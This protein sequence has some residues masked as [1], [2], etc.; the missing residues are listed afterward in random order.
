MKVFTIPV[1][2]LDLQQS[3]DYEDKVMKSN[4]LAIAVTDVEYGTLVVRL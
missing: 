1:L 3:Y 2:N 4:C